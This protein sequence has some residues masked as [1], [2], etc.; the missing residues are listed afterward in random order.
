MMMMMLLLVVALFCDQWLPLSVA[1]ACDRH[2]VT[3]VRP[4]DPA[5]CEQAPSP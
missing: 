2:S 4:F 5:R 3:A 1:A